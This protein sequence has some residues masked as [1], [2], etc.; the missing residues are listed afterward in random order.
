MPSGVYNKDTIKERETERKETKK[1]NYTMV[2]FENGRATKLERFELA[3]RAII[4]AWEFKMQGKTV[5][6][7]NDETCETIYN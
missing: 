7:V 1:M 4:T 6:V 5:K 3:A 2:V